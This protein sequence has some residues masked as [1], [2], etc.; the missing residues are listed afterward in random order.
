MV[1]RIASSPRH[2]LADVCKVFE[3]D[4]RLDQRR[5]GWQPLGK[6]AE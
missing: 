5:E 6:R 4:P 3:A 2:H 1:T